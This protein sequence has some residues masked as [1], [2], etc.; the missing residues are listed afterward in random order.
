MKILLFIL[1]C[2]ALAS[3][4]GLS[5]KPSVIFFNDTDST[6]ADVNGNKQPIVHICNSDKMTCVET[7]YP[8]VCMS[9]GKYRKI[10]TVNPL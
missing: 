9:Q 1:L 8:L 7:S 10:T 5:K 4:N 3:C 2:M 6:I